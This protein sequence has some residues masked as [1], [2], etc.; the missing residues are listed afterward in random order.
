M[1]NDGRNV[2][3]WTKPDTVT[4]ISGSDLSAHYAIT[5]AGDITTGIGASINEL[6]VFPTIKSIVPGTKAD[7]DWYNKLNKNEREK[8]D[9]Y[10]KSPEDFEN[11]GVLKDSIYKLITGRGGN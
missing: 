4:Q 11:D 5:D 1:L 9:A 3:N 2:P 8:Y 10:Q 6:D 7:M